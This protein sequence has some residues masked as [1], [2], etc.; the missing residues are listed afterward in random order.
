MTPDAFRKLALSYPNA[1]E[2]SHMNH[3]DFRINGTIFATR[4]GEVDARA[5]EEICGTGAGRVQSVQRRM[6]LARRNECSAAVSEEPDNSG[7]ARLRVSK[8][9][10]ENAEE[11]EKSEW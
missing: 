10:R 11:G 8:C 9:E 4:D 3:P 7:G 6:G 5:T 1:V 2:S